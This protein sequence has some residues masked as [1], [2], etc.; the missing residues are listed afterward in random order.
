MKTA[1]TTPN[2][3]FTTTITLRHPRSVRGLLAVLTATAR[4]GVVHFELYDGA[5]L[6]SSRLVGEG[7]VVQ[8]IADGWRL[9]VDGK[10][11]LRFG[12]RVESFLESVRLGL[13]A[14]SEA[15]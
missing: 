14:S 13:G 7:E 2:S 5:R 11:V 6:C 4:P 15:A 12:A 9:L 10:P 3:T 1:R 8:R